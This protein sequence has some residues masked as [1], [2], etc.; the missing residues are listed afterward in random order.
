MARKLGYEPM[1]WQCDMWDTMY[2]Y[3]LVD[4]V[5]KLW[6]REARITVPR[7]SA[8]TTSTLVRQVHRVTHSHLHGWGSRPVAAFTMQ[9]ASDARD[10][11]V[12][13][14]MPIVEYSELV[15]ELRGECVEKGFLRSNGK[16][17]MLWATGGRMITFPPNA[18]GAHGGT[19]DLVD[20]DEAFAFPDNRAEQGSRHTMITRKSPQIVIQS[21]AGTAESTYLREK[22]DNGRERVTDQLAGGEEGHVYYLEYSIGPED[23]INNPDHWWRWMPA[24]GYTIDIDA[25]MLEYDAMK[26]TPDEFFRAYG[27][28]WTGSS[29]QIIPAADWA[30]CYSP[31]TARTGKVWMAVDVSPGLNGKGRAASIAVASFRG[32]EI[33][34]EIIAHGAGDSWVAEKLGELTRKHTVQLL[35]IDTTGPVGEILPDIKLLAMA[36]LEIADSKTMAHACGR[37]LSGVLD[38]VV[39]HRDQPML[40]AAVEGAAKRVLDDSWAWKRRT[41]TSDISPLVA[42]TLAAW[43]AAT[44][45]DRGMIGMHTGA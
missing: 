23:D 2:E 45:G 9:H 14:W 33:H 7:Q 37:L 16:E 39:R 27:N 24:L 10:K 29:S 31:K 36:N 41:S 8:K 18:T 6:Y 34:T 42:I 1:P 19:F 35:Y 22:V 3:E 32:A 13:D 28:G 26:G 17:S 20:I 30:A 40:T 4:G 11:M 38:R 25:V 43:G 15:P 12:N 5:K 44:N 21:T